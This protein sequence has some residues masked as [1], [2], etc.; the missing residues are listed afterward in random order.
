MAGESGVGYAL[1]G[2]RPSNGVPHF[3]KGI[4]GRRHMAPFARDSSAVVNVL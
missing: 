4:P 2:E 1:A 3:V